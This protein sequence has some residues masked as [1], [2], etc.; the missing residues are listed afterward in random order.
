V[1]VPNLRLLLWANSP[2]LLP[3]RA[4]RPFIVHAQYLRHD[5]GSHH[6]F[7]GTYG[8]PYASDQWL[9][10]AAL[11]FYGWIRNCFQPP[12][13]VVCPTSMRWPSGSRT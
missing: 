6:A 2:T 4:S 10:A 9:I 11:S 13:S 5:D 1:L 8:R 3:S 12:G 7:A